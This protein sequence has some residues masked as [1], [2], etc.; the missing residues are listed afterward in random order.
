MIEFLFCV[1]WYTYFV[2]RHSLDLVWINRLTACPF[3][4]MVCCLRRQIFLT[5]FYLLN[6]LR[7]IWKIEFLC[8]LRLGRQE[9]ILNALVW[10]TRCQFNLTWWGSYCKPWI[11]DYLALEIIC[12]ERRV[13]CKRKVWVRLFFIRKLT[14]DSLFNII[15]PNYNCCWVLLDLHM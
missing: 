10:I 3:S 15:I 14:I 8:F 2:T 6:V 12:N 4:Q 5:W 9:P 1:L 7:L 13:R 11:C